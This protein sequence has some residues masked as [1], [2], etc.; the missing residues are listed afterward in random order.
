MP[1]QFGGHYQM[2]ENAMRIF[3]IARK[4]HLLL[5]LH[6]L[7]AV[8][9]LKG[10]AG[11]ANER[12][13]AGQKRMEEA[14]VEEAAF[15]EILLHLATGF[16]N[17][18]LDRFDAA[19]DEM[20]ERIGV[21]SGLD[22]VYVFK[23]DHDNQV[24]SNTH[25]WCAG[26][27]NPEIDNL[28]GIPFDFFKDML[29]TWQKGEIVHIPSVE[30]MPRTHAM[31]SILLDQGIKS[32]V[33]IPLIH[34][35]KNTGFV[36][37]D[38][39]REAKHF[40]EREITLLI[41]LAEII[42]NA[43]SRRETEE[44]LRDSEAKFR[45]FVENSHDIIYM[46]NNEGV[47]T[48]VSPSWSELL[49]YE[50]KDV[51]GK[52]FTSFLYEEDIPRILEFQARVL[53]EEHQEESLE[54]RINHR[55]GTLRWHSSNGSLLKNNGRF[56]YI[57]VARDITERKKSI[58]ALRE[59]E[60][61]FRL[62]AEN[63]SDI[64]WIM[65]LDFKRSYVSPSVETVLGF[66]PDESVQ[67]TLEQTVTPSSIE[68]IMETFRRE[69]ESP[70]NK[71]L[72]PERS[73]LVEAEYYHK[74]G[75]TIWLENNCK[76]M[77]DARG[78]LVGLYGVSRDISERKKAEE[79]LRE[80][81]AFQKILLEL[82][83]NFIN[84]PLED[85]DSA[86]N[87]M[88]S[89]I[90][91]FTGVDR[92]YVFKHDYAH[93][94]TS[95]TH[96][97]CA[98]GISSELA[99]MQDISLDF[100]RDMLEVLQR[101][102]SI[103]IN[104]VESTPPDHILRPILEP[105]GIKS[106]VLFP[107]M[108]NEINTGFV[109]FD[110]V[111]EPMTFS[112]REINLLSIL[113]EIIANAIARQQAEETLL[114]QKNRLA[115]W[116]LG[117]EHTVRE[118]TRAV[119][120]LLDN[121][122]QGF[123]TFGR[124]LAVD[125]DYSAECLNIF[126]EPVAGKIISTLLFPG[127]EEEQEIMKEI[128]TELERETDPFKKVIYLDLLPEEILLNGRS[129][130]LNYKMIESESI[131]DGGQRI[132]LI[133]TDIT[134]TRKLEA[135]L[136]EERKLFE[137]V[138]RVVSNHVDFNITLKEYQE[139]CLTWR[140]DLKKIE[141]PL[142]AFADSCRRI[143]TFKGS[144]HQFAMLNTV[145]HLHELENRLLR[146]SEESPGG[147]SRSKLEQVLAR[148]EMGAWIKKDLEMLKSVLGDTLFLQDNTLVIDADS[149]QDLENRIISTLSPPEIKLLLPEIR[150]LSW[151]PFRNA[152]KAYPEYINRLCSGQEKLIYPL[153][154]EGGEVKADLEFYRDF[155][156]ALGHVF[157]NALDHGI[158]DPEERVVAGKDPRGRITCRV[159]KSEEGD[160]VVEIGDDG[161][162]LSRP[163]PG[164]DVTELIFKDHFS[165][166]R[167][168]TEL[169]GRGVGLPAVKQEV[170]KLGGRMKVNS[171]TGKGTTFS[172]Y[173]PRDT[174]PVTEK[175]NTFTAINLFLQ[176][177]REVLKSQAGLDLTDT[178][179]KHFGIK[180]KV[181]LFEVTA[182]ISL[183]GIISGRIIFSADKEVCSDMLDHF[184]LWDIQESER[185]QCYDDIL[186]EM[187]NVIIKTFTGKLPGGDLIINDPPEKLR[188][189][190]GLIKTN[191]DRLLTYVITLDRGRLAFAFL[192]G[193]GS[194]PVFSPGL[195]E[196][197][198][199]AGGD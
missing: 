8:I 99:N 146:L 92:A 159:Q 182:M 27:I 170:E 103:H 128:I 111:K 162:G 2:D 38:A 19:I 193:Q 181:H 68:N 195:V 18:P 109:G 42:S 126:G 61:K 163:G 101:G 10:G 166:T 72:D 119:R 58:E 53:Q 165:T 198:N 100:Y 9:S 34:G 13:S 84:V 47:F 79:A 6:M 185:E 62:L 127:N 85:F 196:H 40:S 65:D 158:E 134:A 179:N 23:H 105:Q 142:S 141:N 194:I 56:I 184:A 189:S 115:E 187:L 199:G 117:L 71:S 31:R 112:A 86:V 176:S 11:L 180:A 102:E 33:L 95:N 88:L 97:W 186:A 1:P 81:E 156:K 32:L 169:S 25:E 148:E 90:G 69:L 49:G 57:G 143:H 154:I 104:S 120:N 17:V 129:I 133:L 190:E 188:S 67:Q 118:R 59:S 137:M 110:A 44:A 50:V 135:H 139:F 93:R 175:V 35:R 178:I 66:T 55:D 131:Q 60:E 132:M 29:E 153:E 108:Q 14:L 130:K 20:L 147:Q 64:V 161:R 98:E 37:F 24:T 122:G 89:D 76:P 177:A 160:L 36:G 30:N 150:K 3:C 149:L 48:Y 52:P 172:F 171:K 75:S 151:K 192:P 83:K 173:L 114:A 73:V 28:Q 144:F 39:V 78:N 5:Y 51:E 54:Y 183:H 94:V 41:V 168:V 7:T 174:E 157:R 116:N 16:I 152:L 82:S 43:L 107:L 80:E 4:F 77:F 155:I 12:E 167:N 74:N 63:M 96:E 91:Q 138:V 113:A 191:I 124:D 45:G 70:G 164:K 46:L 140:E 106:L 125:I 87:A 26:G 197:F 136:A 145:E 21:F 123:L 15:R 22:R 121:A